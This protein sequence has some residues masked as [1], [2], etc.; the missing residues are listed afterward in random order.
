MK[1]QAFQMLGVLAAA[2]M[3][4]GG[5]VLGDEFGLPARSSRY[6]FDESNVTGKLRGAPTPKGLKRFVIDGEEVYAINEKNAI[7]KAKR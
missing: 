5:L 1:K 3:M 4:D 7:R 2:S 6:T